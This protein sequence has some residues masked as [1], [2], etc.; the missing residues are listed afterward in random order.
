MAAPPKPGRRLH[1]QGR[2][3]ASFSV[4]EAAFT[5]FRVVW[6]RPLVVAVWAAI[7]VASSF[8]FSLFLTMTAGAAFAQL[9]KLQAT[10]A[11]QRDP[12]A[13]LSVLGQ[14]APT[15]G[16][17]LLFSLL[18]YPLLYAAMNRA[19]MRPRDH[20]FGYLRVGADELRQLALMLI[21]FGLFLAVYVGLIVVVLVVAVLGGIAASLGGQAVGAIIGV[22]IPAIVIVAA[23]CGAALLAVRLSLASAMTYATKRVNFIGSWNLTAGSF[24][25]MLGAYLLATGMAMVVWL[26]VFAVS[27]AAASI[28]SG[29]QSPMA[30]LFAPDMT[31]PA[32]YFTPARIAYL[33]L[34]GVSQALI[35]PLLLTPAAT[36]YRRL[37][38]AHGLPTG[39]DGSL[40][41]VFA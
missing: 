27:L 30:V 29:G 31:S 5:G 8:G 11:A 35:W 13:V 23:I 7:A 25:P 34:S 19:V 40:S 22:L 1:F 17:L 26:L 38:P 32:A 24:W 9:V 20:A 2:V 28:V 10:N 37:A 39:A 36:I 18:F 12:T 4:A 15:Y 16:L 3:L 41:D 6:E 21:F 33:V 14:L